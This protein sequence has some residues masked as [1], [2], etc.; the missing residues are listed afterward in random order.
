MTTLRETIVVRRPIEEAFDYVADFTTTAEWDPGID[1]A[2]RVNG[3]PIG[4]GSRFE[5]VSNFN[6]RKLPLVYTMTAYERPRR[7]VLLG[8]GKQF[9][10]EDTITFEALGEGQTRITYVAEIRL[11]GVLRLVQ[12]FLGGKFDAMGKAAVAGLQARLDGGAIAP[13]P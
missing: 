6:G 11:K 2:K 1:A 13:G 3:G 10:G 4:V 12:P 8:D 5:V 9:R 7:V